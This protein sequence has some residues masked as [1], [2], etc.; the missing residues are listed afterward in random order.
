[1]PD[2]ILQVEYRSI[3]GFPEWYRVGSDGTVWT[4][5]VRGSWRHHRLGEWRQLK[6]GRTDRGYH[7][8]FIRG[9]AADKP[10]SNHVHRLVL[11]AFVGERPDGMHTR[12]L[13]GNPGDSRLVNLAYG[14]PA[15]NQADRIPHGRSNRGERHGR[16]KLSDDGVRELKR[17]LAAGESRTALAAELGVSYE[18]VRDIDNGKR[19]AHVV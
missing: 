19:W 2:G 18:T 12:H 10:K 7:T 8:V 14:T 3:P 4:K 1:M 11:L 5:L 6:A 16:A 13:N 9:V 17:R 15:E